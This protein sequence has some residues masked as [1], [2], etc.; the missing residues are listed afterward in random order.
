MVIL[1]FFALN[2]LNCLAMKKDEANEEIEK[3]IKVNTSPDT[4]KSFRKLFPFDL[5]S[6]ECK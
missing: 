5:N 1:N 3:L 6:N 4:E 2:S